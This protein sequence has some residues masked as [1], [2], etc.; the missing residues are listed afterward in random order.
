M[1]R[2]RMA[3]R[4]GIDISCCECE[5]VLKRGAIV[6][7]SDIDGISRG[8]TTQSSRRCTSSW[9]QRSDSRPTLYHRA[10]G[11][12]LAMTEGSEIQITLVG[13]QRPAI[14][15]SPV[16]DPGGGSPRM[17]LCPVGT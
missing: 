11:A 17:R 3:T 12:R 2:T 5:G 8:P 4:S 14:R 9:S 13:L 7:A 16:Y 15:Q 10:R 1:P 6:E